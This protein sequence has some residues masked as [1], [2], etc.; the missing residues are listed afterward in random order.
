[1][2]CGRRNRAVRACVQAK[3]TPVNVMRNIRLSNLLFLIPAL[4]IGPLILISLIVHGVILDRFYRVKRWYN[5]QP[6]S[7]RIIP[8]NI[9]VNSRR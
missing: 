4:I 7:A 1:M 8:I 9:Y 6:D 5:R 3:I 2:Q